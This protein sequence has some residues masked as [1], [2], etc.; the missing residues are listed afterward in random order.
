MI[1]YIL[2]TLKDF[3]N[4]EKDFSIG[5]VMRDLLV[6]TL[7]GE[8]VK[9]EIQKIEKSKTETKTTYLKM[10]EHFFKSIDIEWISIDLN[11]NQYL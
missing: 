6:K 11:S 8:K 1:P 7:S 3:K 4:E 10:N 5:F 2:L 9:N